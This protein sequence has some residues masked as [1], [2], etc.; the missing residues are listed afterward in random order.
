MGSV[1]LLRYRTDPPSKAEGVADVVVARHRRSRKARL[2]PSPAQAATL[3][4]QGHASR[5]LWN[6]LHEWYTCR[7]GGIARRPSASEIDRQL[8][9]ARVNPPPGW[10]WLGDLP[11]Q[12]TQQVLK[13]YLNAWDRYFRRICKAPNFKKRSSQMSIDAPQASALKLVRLSRKWGRI[14]ILLVGRV[15]FRWTRPLPG[16]ASRGHLGRITGARLIK[17]PLGWHVCFRIEEPSLSVPGGLGSPVGVDRGV[18]H[19]MALS[20]GEMLDMPSLLSSGEQRRLRG[21]ERK[22]ARQQLAFKQLT[23]D[24]HATISRRQRHTYEQIAVLRN[25]QAR[26]RQ[27]WLHKTTTDLAKSHSVVVIEDLRIQS[28]TRSARGTI[29]QPGSN[30]R[31]KA[32]LNRSI[33]GMAWGK[34]EQMLGYKCPTQGGV[35]IKVDPRGSSIECASC[36]RCS[37][38][39]RINQAT[40]RCVACG[41]A[42]NAD[43]NAAEVLLERG[44]TALSGATPGCGGTAREARLP[45][46]HREPL[47]AMP[48]PVKAAWTDQEHPHAE[49]EEDIKPTSISRDSP[50]G[51]VML[52]SLRP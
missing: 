30:V 13:H 9:E 26:R 28:L 20:T 14:N 50:L 2:Y 45:V 6:L 31:A 46:P 32:G 37:P 24:R 3:D 8:R 48:A 41:H 12:A 35:L 29:E 27:D 4:G 5:A 11:A 18:V 19:T 39:S 10:E 23:H 34:T 51:P 44:L 40:F 15:R 25:R 22:A 7:R 47:A 52:N 21:L 42:T 33:L 49:A 43:T 38:T 16:G 17:D 36:G 1:S